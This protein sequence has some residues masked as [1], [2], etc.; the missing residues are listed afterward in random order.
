MH[1]IAAA[2]AHH[3]AL[4]FPIG[5]KGMGSGV[6]LQLEVE[7]SLIAVVA[8]MI[9]GPWQGVGSLTGMAT[10]VGFLASYRRFSI[11]LD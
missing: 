1:A 8:I 9:L 10:S 3:L 6:N 5:S 4:R 7:P 11:F 2:D